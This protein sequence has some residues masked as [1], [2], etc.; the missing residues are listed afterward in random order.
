MLT[1]ATRGRTRWCG[2]RGC[3]DAVGREGPRAA[4]LHEGVWQCGVRGRG[5]DVG[6]E[7]PRTEVPQSRCNGVCSSH[8]RVLLSSP[9]QGD[10]EVRRHR[11]GARPVLLTGSR[12]TGCF[13]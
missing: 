2:A 10:R 3:G 7:G 4:A 6:R 12:N 11:I 1:A 13:S 5:G 8:H 9:D